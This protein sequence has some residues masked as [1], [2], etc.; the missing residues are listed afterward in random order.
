MSIQRQFTPPNT[1]AFP[2][3][4]CDTLLIPPIPKPPTLSAQEWP[5]ALLHSSGFPPS[6]PLQTCTA[7]RISACWPPLSHQEH[8]TA[9]PS[10]TRH[11]LPPLSQDTVLF[12]S[13]PTEK[14]VRPVKMD[15]KE[16]K[17]C[18]H[19]YNGSPLNQCI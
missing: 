11:Q 15:Q 13:H 5:D 2:S 7:L 14:L 1:S 6:L 17:K 9:V 8:S 19:T 16:K 4:L 12:T 18:F 10:T 3:D